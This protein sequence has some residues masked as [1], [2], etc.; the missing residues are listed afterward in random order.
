MAVPVVKEAVQVYVTVPVVRV[1]SAILVAVFE[2]IIW[3]VGVAVTVAT[4]SAVTSKLKV[5][6]GQ[7]VGI[8]PVGLITYLTTPGEEPVLVK[9]G[10]MEGMEP[11][12]VN[13]VIV[14]PVGA[15][16]IDA[17]QV[18]VAPDVAEVIVYPT[19]ELVQIDFVA[20][21]LTTGVGLT[22]MVKLTG[23]PV[24]TVPPGELV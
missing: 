4:G 10:L 18:K 5:L 11:E 13:P 1:E 16:S 12:V 14:P 9:I 2:Q 15:V 23:V 6:P 24:Q 20:A 3:E 7:L 19:F 8:G 21:L 17:V 22:V